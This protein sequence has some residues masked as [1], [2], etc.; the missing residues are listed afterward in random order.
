MGYRRSVLLRWS[1][2]DKLAILVITVTVAFLTGTTLVLTATGTQTTTI[3]EDF[4]SD[5]TATYYNS[6]E[7]A[8][9]QSPNNAL[10]LPI[11][12]VTLP[13]GSQQYVIGIPPDAARTF[14]KQ[15]DITIPNPPQNGVSVSSNAGF[16][17]DSQRLVGKN[18]ALTVPVTVDANIQSKATVP[19]SWYRTTPATVRQLGTTGAFVIELPTKNAQTV[20][21]TG[22]PLRSVLAFFI[23]GTRQLLSLV[24]LLAVGGAV[25]V[26]V[27]VHSITRMTVRDRIQTIRLIR[28]TGG[29]STSIWMLFGVRALLL[30]LV[31]IASGY[32]V[33]IIM[34]RAAVNFAVASGF[35]ISLSMTVTTQVARLLAIGFGGVALTGLLA[36]IS[37]AWPASRRSPAA[38]RHQISHTGSSNSLSHRLFQHFSLTFLDWRALL[39]STTTLT[40]FATV[41]LVGAS[42]AGVLTP[43]MNTGNSTI[44]EPGAVH[45]IGSKVP[46]S[47]ATTLQEQG[48]TAS[49][50]L[51]L[52]TVHNGNSLLVRGVD[53]DSF[54]ILSDANVEQGRAPQSPD[55][56]VIGAD[57]ADKRDIQVGDSITLGGS[58]APS[59]TR[60]K[61]VGK[62]SASGLYD[63]QLLVS[64][65]TGQHLSLAK[66]GMVHFIRTT[67]QVSTTSSTQSNYTILDVTAPERIAVTQRLPVRIR[68]QNFGSKT[69]TRT[70]RAH[71]G[72]ETRKITVK[73]EAHAQRTVTL[74]V[75]VRTPGTQHIQVGTQRTS[76][77]VLPR[78]GLQIDGLPSSAP[79]SSNPLVTVTNTT[80][81]PVANASLTI[82]NRTVETNQNGRVR[83]P[84]DE[85]GTQ[86]LTVHH[87]NQSKTQTINVSETASR[88]LVGQIRIRPT[89]PSIA[90]RPHARISLYNPWQ[91][92][93]STKAVVSTAGKQYTRTVS[94]APGQ[95]KSTEIQL[96]RMAPG[97]YTARL[98]ASERTLAV[99]DYTVSGDDRIVAA[100]ANQGAYS[101]SSG[102]G[103]ILETAFGNLTF[104]VGILS[105]LAGVMTIGSTTATFAQA[106]HARRQ[107]IGVHRAT[108]AIPYQVARLILMDALKIGAVATVTAFS[109]AILVTAILAWGGFL[110]IFGIQITPEITLTVVGVVLCGELMIIL[111][112]ALL[113]TLGLLRQQPVSLFKSTS[114][115]TS[116]GSQGGLND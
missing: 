39:P 10:V 97:S 2:R 109:S 107:A 49:P 35:P 27:V 59:F 90:V 114:R 72:N 83:V 94:V 113:V 64:L 102:V 5:G 16:T 47:Y 82:G 15:T 43:L 103:S 77:T 105:V 53:F 38:L 29:T 75:P 108:G 91:T 61:V 73:L 67:K 3:A 40:V 24:T 56:A 93:V 17:T 101:G 37:A 80:G 23:V 31:G 12:T 6:L 98:M 50:E 55:E 62:Y 34:T 57:I 41:V 14:N 85:P 110:T 100:Y 79:L 60:V 44:T 104:L 63:D 28:S 20:P 70:V 111:F 32:A 25:L 1:H 68:V 52:F 30:T 65:Q 96:P 36:G 19:P 66:P 69:I 76:V 86:T 84:L 7:A 92:K 8:H 18:R 11:A 74:H 115:E 13:N 4:D 81:T 95:N 45:P 112:S 106:I 116:T 22:V 87:Q 58:T 54:A 46:S 33:G 9:T 48:N 51:L 99:A 21:Q 42:V 71:V 88:T 78:N 26:G 89:N